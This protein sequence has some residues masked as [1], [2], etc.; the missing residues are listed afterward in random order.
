MLPSLCILCRFELALAV[1]GE[2]PRVA[3]E[4]VLKAKD[5]VYLK[6]TPRDL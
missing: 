1:E 4:I 3:L 6:A 2:V 5:G